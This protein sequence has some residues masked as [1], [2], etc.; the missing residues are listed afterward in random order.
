MNKP[1]CP[2]WFYI[3]GP[4]LIKQ[5]LAPLPVWVPCLETTDLSSVGLSSEVTRWKQQLV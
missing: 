4:L 1:L 2:E 5:Y 3:C